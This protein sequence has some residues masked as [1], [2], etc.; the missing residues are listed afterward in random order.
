MLKLNNIINL[1]PKDQRVKTYVYQ[2]LVPYLLDIAERSR[3]D[4]HLAPLCHKL[5]LSV[6]NVRALAKEYRDLETVL[7]IV[8]E[9]IKANI[10]LS[11]LVDSN[12]LSF[13]KLHDSVLSP[14]S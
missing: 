2:T 7:H 6:D 12:S 3:Y 14:G 9:K 13:S 4:F 8:S 1:D 10:F 11:Y 5:G